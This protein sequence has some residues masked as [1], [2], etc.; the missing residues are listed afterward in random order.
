MS[1]IIVR[2]NWGPDM[3]KL[4]INLG[5]ITL[6]SLSSFGQGIPS[7]T[8]SIGNVQITL[9]APLAPTLERLRVRFSVQQVTGREEWIIFN[10]DRAPIA[11]LGA[12]EG[13]VQGVKFLVSEHEISSAQ[14]LFDA[15]FAAARRFNNLAGSGKTCT[16]AIT[17]EYHP[18][19][20]T[21][22]NSIRLVCDR[23]LDNP[24]G[25]FRIEVSRIAPGQTG[26]A[27]FDVWVEIGDPV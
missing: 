13:Q 27:N 18:E 21:N 9:N 5:L 11:F 19:N 10:S 8:A 3:P 24:L 23:S 4:L 17:S 20:A 7:F 26:K 25:T 14:D 1:A 12:R 6:Y 22:S 15:L 16:V 2:P